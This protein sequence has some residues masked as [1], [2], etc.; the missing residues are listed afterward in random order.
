MAITDLTAN[1]I[2]GSGE[3]AG[4]EPQRA[5]NSILQ[6]LGLDGDEKNILQLSLQSFPIPKANVGVIEL[7]YLNEKRKFAGI[8]SFDDLS[9]IFVDYVD[10]DTCAIL[11]RWFADVYSSTTGQVG[12]AKDYK[13]DG[14]VIQY[15]PDG[16]IEREY[17]IFG[18][19]ISAIDPGDADMSSEDVLRVTCTIT[20]DKATP[21]FLGE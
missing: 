1:H 15:S 10:K 6:V 2:G 12:M 9:V 14:K 5:N 17:D 21:K 3:N 7:N 4:Y 11:Q 16:S 13:K 19:W 18:M 8:A 20:I